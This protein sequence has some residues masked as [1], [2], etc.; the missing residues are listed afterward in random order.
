MKRAEN[1]LQQVKTSKA[2]VFTTPIQLNR[3]TKTLIQDRPD[4]LFF[5][6]IAKYLDEIFLSPDDPEV[7]ILSLDIPDTDQTGP[8]TGPFYVHV[9]CNLSSFLLFVGVYYNFSTIKI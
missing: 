4:I 8:V 3:T 2:C 9:R 1:C 7:S 5:A 6:P